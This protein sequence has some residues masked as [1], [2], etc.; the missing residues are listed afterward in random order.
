M[1]INNGSPLLDPRSIATMRTVVSGV[2]PYDNINST[3]KNSS[4][5]STEYGLIWNWRTI[6]NHRFIGHTGNMPG[7][8]HGMMINERGNTGVIILSNGDSTLNNDLAKKIYDT[9]T[10]IQVSLIHCFEI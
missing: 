5:P 3:S 8:A 2:I 7:V 1:F 6:G 10:N 9:L 4:L